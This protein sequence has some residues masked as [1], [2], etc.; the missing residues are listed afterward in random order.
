MIVSVEE[1][2]LF[3]SYAHGAD[4]LGDVDVDV[5]VAL[6]RRPTDMGW[7]TANQMRA[8]T[9][10]RRMSF[11]EEITWGDAE[12]FRALRAASR[13]LDIRPKQEFIDAGFAMTPLF[14]AS[15]S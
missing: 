5:A 4:D 9:T 6:Q 10:G 15:T 2:D 1:V 11:I 7:T 14:R 8:A 3:G 12:V 13:R